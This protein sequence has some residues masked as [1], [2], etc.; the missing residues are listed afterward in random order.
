MDRV[1]G[2]NILNVCVLIFFILISIKD[3]KEKI[4]PDA[5]TLGII[6][7]GILKTIFFGGDFERS[8]I[9]FGVYPIIFIFIYG[10]ISDILK[11]E[12]TGFGDIKLLGAVGFYLG[13]SGLYNFILFHNI[14]FIL[15]FIFVLPLL[16]KK[17]YKSGKEI[18]FAP[19]ICLGSIIYNF[20]VKL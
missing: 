9:G 7:L 6:F 2:E 17:N 4:I 12:V 18:P 15:G 13:Y 8:F 16:F 14:I 1:I 10:Y 11:K 5:L 3:I 20:M 19:F